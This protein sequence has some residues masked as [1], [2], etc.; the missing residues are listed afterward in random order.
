M[1]KQAINWNIDGLPL[2]LLDAH[3]FGKYR[4]F[5]TEEE[6]KEVAAELEKDTGP[7]TA[8]V[9]TVNE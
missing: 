6:A 2:V 8:T 1:T 9:F 4:L 7:G 5:D 3:E